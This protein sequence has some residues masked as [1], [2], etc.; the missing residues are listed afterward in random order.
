MVDMT[1]EFVKRPSYQGVEGVVRAW[2][3][4]VSLS[5]QR[6]WYMVVHFIIEISKDS[7]ANRIWKAGIAITMAIIPMTII[8]V[9]LWTIPSPAETLGRCPGPFSRAVNTVDTLSTTSIT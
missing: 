8:V 9:T 4:R 7:I 1:E 3:R 6:N 2:P 5:F